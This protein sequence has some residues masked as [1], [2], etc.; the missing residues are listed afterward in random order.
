MPTEYHL[1][2]FGLSIK[3]LKYIVK[4]YQ[5][6][7][8]GKKF[9]IVDYRV[10][11][12]SDVPGGI[13]AT[14]YKINVQLKEKRVTYKDSD[15]SHSD[16]SSDADSHGS[17]EE[18]NCSFFMKVSPR[19]HFGKQYTQDLAVFKKECKIY[20]HLIPRLQDIGIGHEP[21]APR[22]YLS[23]NEN[24]IVLA[25]LSD[26]GFTQLDSRVLD[27]D[28]L[29]V[30]LQCVA[31]MHASSIALEERTRADVDDLYRGMLDENGYPAHEGYRRNAVTVMTRT[32]SEL[33]KLLPGYD[34]WDRN[35]IVQALPVFINQIFELVKPSNVYRNVVNHSDL[36]S[37][38]ILFKYSEKIGTNGEIYKKPINARLVD[39]QFSRY[40][41]GAYDLA[42][43][44]YTSTSREFRNKHLKDLLKVYYSTLEDELS[45]YGFVAE[46]IITEGQFIQSYDV[47]KK[48]GLLES[49]LFDQVI[50]FPV[51]FWT[52]L[53]WSSEKFESYIS[54]SH[55][56]ICVTAF[57]EHA[58]YRDKMVE[59]LTEAIDQYVIK[60][61]YVEHL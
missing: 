25:N 32:L 11:S 54:H 51:D 24:L 18:R 22:C 58:S 52:G 23:K 42:C 31:R 9:S 2:E 3:D 60:N 7:H 43:L 36:W 12:F 20:E 17:C 8:G 56:E 10:K 53:T 39:F 49:I 1:D 33:V 59:L 29:V 45:L 37:N 48:A 28:H 46:D 57:K 15:S 34:D 30:A 13:L 41:P 61:E 5:T 27:Y 21:W 26:E 40:V 16:S 14:H 55:T 4:R 50:F 35:E 44:F 47:Y 38:N 6:S 19:T